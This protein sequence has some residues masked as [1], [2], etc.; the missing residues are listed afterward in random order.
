M[1]TTRSFGCEIAQNDR[2][3]HVARWYANQPNGRSARLN[4]GH[5]NF[6]RNGARS[7]NQTK[8]SSKRHGH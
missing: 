6:L 7:S 5:S 8:P 4:E 1:Q 3:F 2:R